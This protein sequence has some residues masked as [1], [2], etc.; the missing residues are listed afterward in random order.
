[1]TTVLGTWTQCNFSV[2]RFLC[3]RCPHTLW[4]VGPAHPWLGKPSPSSWREELEEVGAT[5]SPHSGSHLFVGDLEATQ[6]PSHPPTCASTHRPC[7]QQSPPWELSRFSLPFLSMRCCRLCLTGAQPCPVWGKSWRQSKLWGREG[8]G[9]LHGVRCQ[10]GP[11]RQ[12]RPSAPLCMNVRALARSSRG[13]LL[14]L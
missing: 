14:A 13:A 4:S 1:M 12:P 10:V 3:P 6:T 8:A 11:P 9:C 7:L 2:A 5:F